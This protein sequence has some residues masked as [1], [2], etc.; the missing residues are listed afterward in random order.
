MDDFFRV[1]F[2]LS[3]IAFTILSAIAAV[4][5]PILACFWL[6]NHMH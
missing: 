1:L 2:G 5:L 3:V 6:L 4:A